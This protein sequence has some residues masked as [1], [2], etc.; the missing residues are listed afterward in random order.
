MPSREASH[1]KLQL[2]KNIY[3]QLRDKLHWKVGDQRTLFMVASMYAINGRSF[4]INRFMELSDYIKAQVGLFSTLK[5]STR[6]AVAAMLDLPYEQPK[7]KFQEF[8]ELYEKLVSDGFSRSVFTY[9]AALV[10]LTQ[11]ELNSN[12][13]D[14]IKRIMQVYN[15]MKSNHF[16]LTSSNDYPLAVL[17]SNQPGSIEELMNRVESFYE[18]LNKNEFRRGN[19]LQFLSHILALNHG[20]PQD[21]LIERCTSLADGFKTSWL[22]PKGQHY[23]SIGLLSLLEDGLNAY[24]LALELAKDLTNEKH[25]KWHKDLNLTIAIH[26]VMSNYVED[27]LSLETGLYT[28]METIIQAQQAAMVAMISAS[29][30]ATTDSSS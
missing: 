11:D 21:K 2:Y 23:P 3:S 24:E 18:Q 25:F 12:Q 28:T 20:V 14:S 27:S 16:F 7:E 5:S 1:Q 26:L 6:F 22:S 13:E 19:D 4:D 17:L 8:I 15:G 9:I 29:S 30:V 10:M